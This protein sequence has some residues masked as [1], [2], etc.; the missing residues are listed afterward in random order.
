MGAPGAVVMLDGGTLDLG[1]VR[2]SQLNGTNDLQ[3]F[4]EEWLGLC[5]RGIELIELQID[6]GCLGE[7]QACGD[8]CVTTP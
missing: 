3:I 8:L 2:D 1:I 7:R 5:N 4:Q 6:A